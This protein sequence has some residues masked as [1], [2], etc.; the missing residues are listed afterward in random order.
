M[1]LHPQGNGSGP[2]HAARRVVPPEDAPAGGVVA[3]QRDKMTIKQLSTI[4]FDFLPPA[5]VA[6]LEGEVADLFAEVT[7]G[8]ESLQREIEC[9]A[10]DESDAL[11]RLSPGQRIVYGEEPA[12]PPPGCVPVQAYFRGE[13]AYER[14][15]D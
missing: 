10:L 1:A 11:A 2:R 4:A 9:F 14:D 6:W 12:A 13:Y 8:D 3:G 5:Q 7:D 15:D